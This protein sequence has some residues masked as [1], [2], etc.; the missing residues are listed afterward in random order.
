[1]KK[2]KLPL[3]IC[4]CGRR[5]T[6]ARNR[7]FSA[8]CS[9]A[10]SRTT[11]EPEDVTETSDGGTKKKIVRHVDEEVR[12]P[13]DLWRVCKID[14]NVWKVVKLRCGKWADYF[15]VRAD[16][17]LKV[18][19]ISA[20]NEIDALREYALKH[21]HPKPFVIKRKKTAS[22]NL[23]EIQIA[24]VH[25][26]KLAWSKETGGSNWDVKI[27]KAAV[28]KALEEL[29]QRT[30]W[31]TIDQVL[32]V[33]GNDLF[34]ADNLQ[35]T[36][37]R[38]T[39]QDVDG[40][41][42]KTY[43]VVRDLMIEC[44]ERL[45]TIAPVYVMVVPGNHDKVTSWQLGDSLYCWFHT[46]EDVEVNNDPLPRKY[47]EWGDCLLVFSHGDGPKLEKLPGIIA[48]ERP[49]LWGKAKHREVH[50]G[51]KHHTR[52]IEYPGATVRISPALCPVDA[53]HSGAGWV[54]SHQ[55]AEAFVFNKIH[56][57]ISQAFHT[58]LPEEEAAA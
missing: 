27:A 5:V 26:A 7:F 19:A 57:R 44:I 36:T 50:T 11:K 43:V 22:G 31:F 35:N 42:H 58:V 20:R 17:E 28:R 56:G 23:L 45:R 16:L 30:A 24:D 9:Q 12:T 6:K 38:G 53:W 54:G 3:C 33:V 1:M 34:T 32:F 4:G 25:F 47:F 51:D 10:A 18:D 49:E 29:V 55:G 41:Y 37:T 21:I 52:V 14:L 40:R 8:A 13:E 2:K 48:S 15:Q 39:S 46:Y